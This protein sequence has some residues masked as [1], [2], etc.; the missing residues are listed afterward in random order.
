[1]L[2]IKLYNSHRNSTLIWN[3]IVINYKLFIYYIIV[4]AAL[5]CSIKQTNFQYYIGIIFQNLYQFSSTNITKDPVY[6]TVISYDTLHTL[7]ILKFI[8]Q[9]GKDKRRPGQ[10]I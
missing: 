1:M 6:V 8:N 4:S 9:Y 5:L 10:T 7:N 3:L 2:R